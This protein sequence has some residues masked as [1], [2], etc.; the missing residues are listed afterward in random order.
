MWSN[1]MQQY[2]RKENSISSYAYSQSYILTFASG[3]NSSPL[4]LEWGLFDY[5]WISCKGGWRGM[6]RKAVL[7]VGSTSADV[8]QVMAVGGEM[9]GPWLWDWR[10]HWETRASGFGM[11]RDVKSNLK[12]R[13]I[14]T[15]W[16]HGGS[17]KLLNLKVD[18]W[19]WDSVARQSSAESG[20]QNGPW[21][22]GQL[23]EIDFVL[24]LFSMFRPQLE[25]WLSG[26]RLKSG[27]ECI[28]AR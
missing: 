4:D 1:H 5:P 2:Q 6:E 9:E 27:G 11:G 23:P 21:A 7:Y 22:A 12:T 24:K 28:K 18:V 20:S 3:K 10:S 19:I 15:V 26:L 17:N 14:W 16:H 8:D 25:A 13:D